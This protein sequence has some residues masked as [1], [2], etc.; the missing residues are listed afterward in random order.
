MRRTSAPK[1]PSRSPKDVKVLIGFFS[2]VTRIQIPIDNCWPS[3]S[4]WSDR[5]GVF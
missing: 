5:G 1:N 3:G 2:G 4:A